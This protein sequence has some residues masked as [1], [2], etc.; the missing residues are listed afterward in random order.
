MSQATSAQG[1]FG[2]GT[3]APQPV[4]P[5]YAQP[6]YFGTGSSTNTPGDFGQGGIGSPGYFGQ[7]GTDGTDSGYFGQ[8][9]R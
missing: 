7:G 6:G 1:Y 4:P 2:L 8:G 5:L 3:T 9:N